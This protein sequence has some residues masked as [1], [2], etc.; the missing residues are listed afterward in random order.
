MYQFSL[1]LADTFQACFH[2][3]SVKT[4]IL[5]YCEN[6]ILLCKIVTKSL[7]TTTCQ[8]K[9][10]EIDNFYTKF[11]KI[12]RYVVRYHRSKMSCLPGPSYSHCIRMNV[13]QLW[14]AYSYIVSE[15][16]NRMKL[17]KMSHLEASEQKLGITIL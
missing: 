14:I 17:A 9:C 11:A 2:T 3:Y 15:L 6:L 7:V 8:L 4:G 12:Y 13:V 10:V 16:R 1:S 5:E